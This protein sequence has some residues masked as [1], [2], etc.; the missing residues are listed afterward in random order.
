MNDPISKDS[1]GELITG[2][3]FAGHIQYFKEIDSTN[4]AAMLAAQAGAAEG[5]LFIAERQLEGRG[6]GGNSWHSEPGAIYLSVVLR[7]RVQANDVLILSLAT[8][9]AVSAAIEQVCGIV[10]DLRW[11]N[12]ILLGERKLGGILCELNIDAGKVRHAVIGV[13]LNVNQS[14]FP[15]GIREVATSLFLE[16]GKPWPRMEFIA[17]LL[18]AL[19]DEYSKM[20]AMPT[21]AMRSCISRFE[22]RSSYARGKRVQVTEADGFQGTTDGL[23]ECGFLRVKTAAGP[24]LVISGGV[25]PA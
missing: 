5:S 17:A 20:Q 18:R 7:P 4:S 3:I 25:R 6:R 11:P 12:D 14:E 16:T 2:T 21:E 15:E 8:G 13:G 1:L 22:A 10:P 9:L 23:D 24:R 19:Q